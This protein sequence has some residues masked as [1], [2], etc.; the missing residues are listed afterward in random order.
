MSKKLTLR[1]EY[2]LIVF[3]NRV[4]GNIFAPNMKEVTGA[5]GNFTVDIHDLYSSPEVFGVI[6]L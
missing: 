2:K 5:S 6:V 3:E 4:L 1:G